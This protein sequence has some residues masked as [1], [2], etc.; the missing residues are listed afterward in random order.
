LAVRRAWLLHDMEEEIMSLATRGFN[1]IRRIF[2]ATKNLATQNVRN[3]A[4]QPADEID[5]KLAEMGRTPTL[6]A[7]VWLTFYLLIAFAVWAH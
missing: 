6:I 2:G 1:D 5:K 4:E 7:V 3:R